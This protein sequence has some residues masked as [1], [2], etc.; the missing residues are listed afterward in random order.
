[1]ADKKKIHRFLDNNGELR[2][3]VVYG[4]EVIEEMR[5]VLDA[6]PLATV[7]LGRSMLGC[8]LMA[9]HLKLGDSVGMYVKGNGALGNFYAEGNYEGAVRAFTHNPKVDL[10]LKNSKLDIRGA[11]GNGVLEIVRTSHNSDSVHRGLVDIQTGE[12]GDDIAFYLYQS[13]QIPSVVALTVDLNPKGYVASAGGVLIEL[14]PGAQE[15]TIQKIEKKVAAAKHLS[16]LLA[17]G[18]S[19]TEILN[20]FLSDFKMVELEHNSFIQYQCRCSTDR[21]KRALI[22]LGHQE[23][24]SMIQETN[25]SLMLSCDFCGKKYYISLGELEKLRSMAYKNTLN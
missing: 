15:D 13:H 19:A 2:A 4:T 9:S 24:D 21:A 18:L 10:P 12:V 25:E 22:L 11:V 6:G 14:M 17:L 7:V 5:K 20:E 8:A 1:M 23:I 16:E 3:S